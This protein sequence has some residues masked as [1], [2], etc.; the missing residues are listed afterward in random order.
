MKIPA[1]CFSPNILF[2]VFVVF[3][4]GRTNK[5]ISGRG[6]RSIKAINVTTTGESKTLAAIWFYDSLYK[7]SLVEI[8]LHH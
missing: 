4:D 3:G 6:R 1:W 2:P 7:N 5:Q 8:Y